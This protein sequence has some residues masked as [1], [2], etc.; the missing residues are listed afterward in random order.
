MDPGFEALVVLL[1]CADRE[2]YDLV[3]AHVRADKLERP[4][5]KRAMAAAHA[6]A[7]QAGHGPGNDLLVIQ[8]VR[9]LWQDGKIKAEEVNAVV[10]LLDEGWTAVDNGATAKATAPLMTQVL[11]DHVRAEGMDSVLDTWGKGGD[12]I[13]AS[14][15]FFEAERI[16]R[17]DT[18]LGPMLG[19]GSFD[20]IAKASQIER[21][22]TGVDDLDLFMDGGPARGGVTLWVGGTGDGKSMAM[23]QAAAVGAAF[24]MFVGYASLELPE[25]MCEARL[26]ASLTG[27]PISM[28][29]QGRVEVRDAF[30]DMLDKIGAIATKKFQ[31]SVTSIE[32][33]ERWVDEK[34]REVG[35]K[36]DMLC[37]DY[38]DRAAAG[39]LTGDKK[40]MRDFS[41]YQQGEVA[42]QKFRDLVEKKHMY[43]HTASQATRRDSARKKKRLGVDDVADSMHKPRIADNVITLNAVEQMDGDVLMYVYLAKHRHGRAREMFGPYPAEFEVARI[44]PSSILSSLNGVNT[45]GF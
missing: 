15:A 16:G 38:I 31:P 18:S 23:T 7:K 19:M 24:G 1:A 3:G 12:L 39:V 37:L 5:A 9:R 6:I 14:K 35:K 27:F 45:G 10:D 29:E 33:I 11:Q 30:E 21:H 25:A 17:R 2:F 8:A 44:A 13:H 41:S 40:R 26:I 34:E 20:T 4:E 42:M 43:G 36:M 28:V 22:P 32:D